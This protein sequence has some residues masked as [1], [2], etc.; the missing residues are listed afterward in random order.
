MDVKKYAVLL[1]AIDKGSFIRACEELGYTQSG[2]THMMNS[3]EKEIGFPLLR[4]SNKGIQ[5][6]AEGEEVLPDIREL[7]RLNDRLEQKFSRIRGMETGKIRLGSYP[8]IAS[9]WIPRILHR[10]RE[11]YPGIRVEVQEESSVRK[12]ERN[13]QEGRLDLGIFSRQ[14]KLPLEW[15]ALEEDPYL[16]VLPEDHPLAALDRVPAHQLMG[17]SFLMCKSIDGM[18]PD[19]TRYYREQGLS[20]TSSYSF[21]ADST[22][23]YMVEQKMGVSML[24]RLF[25]DRVLGGGGHHVTVR[26]MDP[27]ASR[28]LGIAVRSLEKLS[29]AMEHFIRCARAVLRENISHPHTDY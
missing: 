28:E 21:N 22:I 6:T 27:P 7:V 18:D 19:I 13:L 12:M 10:F 2:L 23:L 9:A 25:L 5:L 3:L 15:I 4:R 11:L 1:D 16:A 29:P 26:P 20:I 14:P 8:T 24:P 17:E